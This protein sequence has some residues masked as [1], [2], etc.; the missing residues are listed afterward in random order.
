MEIKTYGLGHD[1]D[2]IDS[3]T[4]LSAENLRNLRTERNKL[5]ADCDWTQLSDVPTETKTIWQTY[6]QSLRDMPQNYGSLDSAEGNW[7]TKPE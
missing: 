6:R 2:F 3:V 7:P 5:L 1:S 4:T